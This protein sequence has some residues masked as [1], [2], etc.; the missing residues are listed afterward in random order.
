MRGYIYCLFSHGLCGCNYLLIMHLP[1]T[2]HV[3]IFSFVCSADLL[4]FH[5]LMV[6]VY[7]ANKHMTV[8]SELVF[9]GCEV[10]DI[11]F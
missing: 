10:I 9:T 5:L 2:L 1:M 11:L 8:Y 3:I 4:L 6:I 7:N